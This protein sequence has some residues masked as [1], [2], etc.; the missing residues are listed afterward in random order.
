MHQSS[1][2]LCPSRS[3]IVFWTEALHKT[4]HKFLLYPLFQLVVICDC[5]WKTFLNKDG[6][7]LRRN[8]NIIYFV[9]L[10]KILLFQRLKIFLKADRMPYPFSPC[11]SKSRLLGGLR[12]TSEIH[13]QSKLG[14]D[15]KPSL[16]VTLAGVFPAG[17]EEVDMK[18]DVVWAM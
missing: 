5:N 3:L 1:R 12:A 6:S 9:G 14:P 11:F 13:K 18:T 2:H 7:H 4:R 8:T 17:G 10:N 16:P 15:G